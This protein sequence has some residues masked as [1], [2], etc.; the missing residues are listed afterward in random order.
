MTTDF[1][2]LA[3]I[4][5]KHN[6]FLITTHVNPD[7]DALGSELTFYEI[8]KRLG[9]KVRVVNHSSTPY[10]LD[11]LDEDKIIEKYDEK[12]H[13]SI[14]DEA[15]VFIILDLNQTDRVVRMEKGLIDFKGIKICIDHHQSP[16]IRQPVK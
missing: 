15:E 14:F 12:I 8:L 4:I 7:A 13:V 11:F 2:I 3:N 16:N 10:N 5:N 1:S 6:S 9:K